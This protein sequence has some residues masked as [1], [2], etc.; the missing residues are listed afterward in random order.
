VPR[1]SGDVPDREERLRA[2]GNAVVPQCAEIIGHIIA[3]KL[4]TADH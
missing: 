3:E 2:L 1:T 4:L